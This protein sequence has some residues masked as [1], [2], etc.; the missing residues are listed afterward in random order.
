MVITVLN[1]SLPSPPVGDASTVDRCSGGRNAGQ[2]QPSW[3]AGKLRPKI[4]AERD[5]FPPWIDT[6]FLGAW[7]EQ[8]TNGRAG[9]VSPLGE[10]GYFQLHPAEIIDMAGEDRAA[11][12]TQ[13]I[14]SDVRADIRWGGALLKHYDEAIVRFGIQRGTQLYHGLLKVMHASRPRGIRWL[15]HV[16]AVLGRAPKTYGEFLRTAQAL[17]DGRIQAR[18][19]KSLPSALPTCSAQYVLARRNVFLLPGEDSRYPT[20]RLGGVATVYRG[21]QQVYSAGTAALLST[22]GGAMPAF[23]SPMPWRYAWVKS[24]WGD[25]RSYRGGVHEGLDFAAPTGTPV[26][27]AADGK[28]INVST[29][30]NA[31]LFV[32]LQHADGWATR[33]MHLSAVG[34]AEGQQVEAGD[35]IGS[36]GATGTSSSGPH[37]HFDMSLAVDR[38]R[39]Y[40]ARFGSPIKGFGTKRSIGVAVPSEPLIPVRG[41]AK[42]VIKAARARGVKLYV[43]P[44]PIWPK[45]AVGVGA[46][47]LAALV[48]FDLYQRRGV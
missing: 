31:G 47:A 30:T 17:K 1:Q 34:V 8:E 27:A 32:T 16:V 39:D 48:G 42:N 24:G 25:D 40:V 7:I 41:Y 20:G 10:V 3:W 35:R 9:A 21:L 38:L 15:Q 28:V 45:V 18:I 37:L 11:D 4:V 5:A 13:A 2:P 22:F 14:K 43:A 12:V 26:Y 33:Y 6:A 29:G 46:V 23:S 36:V 44:P 19:E